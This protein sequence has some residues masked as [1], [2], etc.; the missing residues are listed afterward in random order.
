MHRGGGAGA[1]LENMEVRL[2]QNG[3]DDVE[4]PAEVRRRMCGLLMRVSFAA[5]VERR[6]RGADA[7]VGH[8]AASVRCRARGEVRLRA[9]EGASADKSVT[10]A[11]THFC[12]YTT[13]PSG[14]FVRLE[15]NDAMSGLSRFSTTRLR[16][17]ALM[18]SQIT[19]RRLPW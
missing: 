19:C 17:P 10:V 18:I 16:P 6:H 2:G 13:N 14:N 7:G 11:S 1:D 8:L 3:I 5:L 9:G 12:A 4:Q 15:L